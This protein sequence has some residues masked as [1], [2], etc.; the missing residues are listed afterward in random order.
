MD[1]YIN[2]TYDGFYFDNEG[3]ILTA[4]ERADIYHNDANTKH[5]YY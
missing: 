5:D 4:A 3:K 2:A 1:N